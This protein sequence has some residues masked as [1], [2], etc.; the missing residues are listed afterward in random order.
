MEEK[1]PIEAFALNDTFVHLAANG[2]AAPVAVT[3]SFWRTSSQSKR[4]DRLVG[5]FEFASSEDLHS[6]T[7]EMHPEADE[8]LVLLSGAIDVVVERDGAEQTVALEAGQA[9]IVPRG[10]WHRLVM[11]EPGKLLFVNSRTGMSSRRA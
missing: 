8:L 5:S 2:D 3:P 6:S 10:E 9:A 7:Q 4:F 1:R 11:R